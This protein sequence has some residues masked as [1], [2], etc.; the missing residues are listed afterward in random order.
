MQQHKPAVIYDG[1]CPFCIQH[2]ERF[3]R[4]DVD[5]QFEYVP[6]QQPGL[7]ERFPVLASSDFNTGMRYIGADGKVFVGADAVY[8]ICKRL[9]AFRPVAWLYPLPGFNQ[10]SRAVYAWVAANR[11]RLGQTCDS[12]ACKIT[13]PT[14]D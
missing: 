12:D 1:A 9:P 10:I 8:Q 11:K 4:M 13:H 5:A 3:K 2:I 14:Q 6:R 7:E